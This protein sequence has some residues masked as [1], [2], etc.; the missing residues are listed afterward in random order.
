[1]SGELSIRQRMMMGENVTTVPN[2][3]SA[4]T[5]VAAPGLT[6]ELIFETVQLPKAVTVAVPMTGPVVSGPDEDNLISCYPFPV[7]AARFLFR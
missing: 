5:C 6:E 2:S 7:V 3:D 1:M 4:V